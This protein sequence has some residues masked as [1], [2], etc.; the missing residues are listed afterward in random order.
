MDRV[1][2]FDEFYEIVFENQKSLR[3]IQ[4][5]II[6]RDESSNKITHSTTIGEFAIMEEANSDDCFKD[7]L[8]Y[9]NIN[10]SEMDTP[11]EEHDNM[12][13]STVETEDENDN[14]DIDAEYPTNALNDSD[15]N[16]KITG[17]QEFP[18]ELVRDNKL[19]FRGQELINLIQKFYTLCC[20]QC[21]R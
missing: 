11:T 19:I 5:I 18:A 16:R 13:C 1:V 12:S 7:S 10:A 21:P 4:P 9:Q 17:S 15:V 6:F 2:E 20:D 3:N 14:N 8:P